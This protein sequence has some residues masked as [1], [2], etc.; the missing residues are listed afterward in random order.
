MRALEI[1]DDSIAS[2][3]NERNLVEG[4]SILGGGEIFLVGNEESFGELNCSTH[5]SDGLSTHSC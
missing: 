2:I 1:C 4:N 5:L 3:R